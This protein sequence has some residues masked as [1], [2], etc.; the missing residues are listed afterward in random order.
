MFT[1]L[2]PARGTPATVGGDPVLTDHPTVEM[3]R[4]RV[5]IVDD[6]EGLRSLMATALEEAGCTVYQAADGEEGMTQFR[7]HGHEL[8]VVV[9]DLTMP[10]MSGDEVFRR[11]RASRP[12]TRVILCSGYT[13][14]DISRQFDGL[15]LDGF[16]EKPFT[17]SELIEKVG[18]VLTATPTGELSHAPT[19]TGARIVK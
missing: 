18:T 4:T 16:I 5:L 12:Q 3:D 14:E 10:K 17:P 13:E 2:F 1:L 19:S 8:D 7:R 6:E 9:L 11:I 15:G